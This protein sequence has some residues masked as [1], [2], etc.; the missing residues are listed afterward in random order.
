MPDVRLILLLR[1]PIDRA[2]SHAFMDLVK[3]T[4]RTLESVEPAEFYNLF[5]RKGFLSASVYSAMLEN[6][7]SIFPRDQLYIGLFD[8]IESDPRRLLSEVFAHLGV[9][10]DVNWSS[11]PCNDVILPPAGP[12][13]QAHDQGRGVRVA[14]HERSDSFMPTEFRTFLSELFHQD[15]ELLNSRYGLAVKHWCEAP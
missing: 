11:F 15:I 14:D 12:E 5:N 2:W 6:W 4:G 9:T 1:N 13:F 7:L 3:Q 10:A 8:Q